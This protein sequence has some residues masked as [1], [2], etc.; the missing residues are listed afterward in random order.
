MCAEKTPLI[1]V[2]SPY[3]GKDEN[4]KRAIRYGQYVAQKGGIPIIPHTM[5]HGVLNDAVPQQRSVGLEA[6]RRLL[7]MCDAVWVFGRQE[8]ASAGMAAEISL[9]GDIGIPVQYVDVTAVWGADERTLA[10]SKCATHYQE[11]YCTINSFILNEFARY[12]D[13]GITPELICECINKAAAKNAQWAYSKAI[14]NACVH[15]GIYTVEQYYDSCGKKKKPENDFAGY[16]LESFER[17]L[18]E[19]ELRLDDEVLI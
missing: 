12:M 3:A 15:K 4:Y 17:M 13:N 19:K 14:L 10:L 16:D 8:T 18:K 7:K 11:T 5:L 6:G 1:Y 2:C 9:A